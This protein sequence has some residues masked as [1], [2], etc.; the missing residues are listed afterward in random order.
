MKVIIERVGQKSAIDTS[1]KKVNYLLKLNSFP[2]L[3]EIY[4]DLVFG[5]DYSYL[6]L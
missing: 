3:K 5:R 4:I 6:D 2:C 1:M